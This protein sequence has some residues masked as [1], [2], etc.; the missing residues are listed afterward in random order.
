MSEY[1][2]MATRNLLVLL[3]NRDARKR[4]YES[5][6]YYPFTDSA[7][8]RVLEGVLDELT[9]R[10]DGN[11]DRISGLCQSIALLQNALISAGIDIP[12]P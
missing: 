4:H 9:D 1:R 5:N 2:N 7:D 10:I 6:G 12:L 3:A 11:H 8:E